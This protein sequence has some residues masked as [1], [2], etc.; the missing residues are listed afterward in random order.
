MAASLKNIVPLLYGFCSTNG[1]IYDSF[2]DKAQEGELLERSKEIH[3]IDDLLLVEIRYVPGNDPRP[4]NVPPPKYSTGS[5]FFKET[6]RYF[7]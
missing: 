4:G 2:L 7:T 3:G 5:F 1:L 6:Y